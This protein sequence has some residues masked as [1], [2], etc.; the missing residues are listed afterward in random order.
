MRVVGID[1]GLTGALA[2]SINRR[3]V[4]VV[5]MPVI[6]KVVQGNLVAEQLAEWGTEI[7]VLEDI[8]AMPR[9]SIASFSLGQSTGIVIGVVSALS[10]PLV[11][12]RPAMWKRDM[13][14]TGKD[15]DASRLLAAESFPH[16]AEQFKRKKDDGRAEACLI[17]KWYGS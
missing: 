12:V 9:G 13:G 11:R 1:P 8:T 7:V 10:H 14:L 16:L 2:L 17:A 5:D 4:E 6:S 15:K 3:V